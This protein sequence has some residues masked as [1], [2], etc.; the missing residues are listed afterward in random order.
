MRYSYR[1][2]DGE[3]HTGSAVGELYGVRVSV[4]REGV[5]EIRSW[6]SVVYDD[7]TAT[8]EYAL[9]K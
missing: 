3:L 4:P 1:D 6:H 8:P 9:P 2:P 7:G 5:S